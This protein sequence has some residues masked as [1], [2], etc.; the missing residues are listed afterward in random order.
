MSMVHRVLPPEPVTSLEDYVRRRGGGGLTVAREVDPEALIDEIETSGLRG[1]GGAGFPTHIKWR[2][3]RDNDA[4]AM[5]TTVV[6]NG[7]EGEP[8]TYKD[9]TILT[10][11]PYRVIEGALIAALAVGA[12]RVVF[13]LKRSF[14]QVAER[15]RAAC[16]EVVAAG[17]NGS[18]ELDVF[19][20]PDE[21]LYGEETALLE[22][23]DGR[24]PF[25]RIA[26]PFRRGID[27]VVRS[28]ADLDSGSG[29]AATVDMV[30]QGGGGLA[31]P[32][33]VDNVETLANVP[34]IISRG[35]A[36]FRT[37]GTEQSPGTIVCTVTGSVRRA[38][39]GEFL[40]GT[41]L[42]EVIDELGGGP[43]PDRHIVA[44]LGG[45]SQPLLT[46]DQL[47]TP[48]SYEAMAAAGSGLGSAG[49]IVLDD[50]DDVVAVAAGASRFLA[51]ESCGQ[52]SP[53]KSDGR[54]LSDLMGRLSRS[55]A[56]DRDLAAIR[57]RL[58]TVA[59][60]ARCYLAS[61]HQVI[62]SSVLD[63]FPSE[64]EAHLHGGRPGVEPALV[65]ELVRVA[66]G[67]AVWEEHHAAKQPDW[68]YDPVDSGR[69]PADRLDE[70]RAPETLA[71]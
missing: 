51:V 58:A 63:R 5:A 34:R 8:G 30:V 20:G 33:L 14:E 55:E 13:G 61:Q 29:L 10:S 24:Y 50:H 27:E 39:V 57:S 43:L 6:V 68:T 3:V 54:A 21:Y 66:D 23:I 35:G 67:V 4:E 7:A 12:D 60:G 11:D 15:V 28:P 9:R 52:C 1:R 70:H 45:A 32:T 59:D 56:D 65:A 69:S 47:D 48:L 49:F 62:L 44:V 42:R 53:C 17:W 38:G 64:V 22:A 40:M 46:A 37:E 71:E 26:P 18:I 31:P 16:D 41:P 25:P 19:E 36:W 2:T